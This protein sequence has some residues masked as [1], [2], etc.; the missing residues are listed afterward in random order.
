MPLPPEI[1]P[2]FPSK[3]DSSILT[4]FDSCRHKVFREYILGL[5]P[6]AKSPD[7]IAGGAFARGM[8]V[9][10]TEL[11]VKKTNPED[12]LLT[13]AWAISDYWGENDT[14]PEKYGKPHIKS[15]INTVAAL[16]SYFE[17]YPPGK[18]IIKPYI[19]ADGKP[20]IEFSF[21]IEMDVLHP[22][23]NDPLLFCGRCDLLGH[24]N[25]LFCVIDEKTTTSLGPSW[26]Y[27][28]LMRGQFM[29]YCFAAQHFG[30]D[31]STALIRGVAFQVKEIKHMEV[32]ETY[33]QWQIDRWWKEQNHKVQDMVD[34]WNASCHLPLEEMAEMWRHSYGDACSSYGGCVF[35]G[36]ICTSKEPENWLSE[37]DVRRWDPL[38]KDPSIPLLVAG[39]EG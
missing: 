7:L 6:H 2:I 39:N 28:W 30:L 19:Y 27:Q 11:W 9:V 34:I 1:V 15:F 16:Y 25:N 5:T 10:R 33:G 23:S 31:V 38:K 32:V 12:A 3:I 36:D 22:V 20:A 35:R 21:A 4:S 17:E 24:Y 18:D 14:D 8:E 37:Y 13:G 29:G 26:P